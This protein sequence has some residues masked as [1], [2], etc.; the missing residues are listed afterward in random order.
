[1][2]GDMSRRR[3]AAEK[4]PFSTTCTK[5]VRLFSRSMANSIIRYHRI[6]FA[7][8]HLLSCERKQSILCHVE[9]GALV[10]LSHDPQER[11]MEPRL[12][13]SQASPE[14]IQAALALE[15]YVE[16]CGLERSL[17]YLVKTRAS[18]INGCA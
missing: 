4:L 18:Q 7:G 1:M 6:I 13:P 3:A 17:Y 14:S 9:A 10:L 15:K 2:V 11:Q 5:V 12:N 16:N 8:D